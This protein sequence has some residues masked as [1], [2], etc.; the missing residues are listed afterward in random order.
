MEQTIKIRIAIA[1]NSAGQWYAYGED[2][3][4]DEQL[5]RESLHYFD[6]DGPADQIYMAEVEVP[7]PA[8][9]EFLGVL[10]RA[11]WLEAFGEFKTLHAWSKDPRCTV[12][13]ETLRQRLAKGI[14]LQEALVLPGYYRDKVKPEL[15][16]EG[17]YHVI[18]LAEVPVAGLP[19]LELGGPAT[20]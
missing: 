8:K 10:T 1:I 11:H 16:P 19:K 9:K 15:E 13:V 2:R 17:G 4:S 18:D 12:S 3:R 14:S 20:S 5:K 6:E 7:L